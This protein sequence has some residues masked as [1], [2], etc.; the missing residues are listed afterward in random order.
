[1]KKDTEV[2]RKSG[3]GRNPEAGALQ[4]CLQGAGNP[5][6]LRQSELSGQC[7]DEGGLS[8]RTTSFDEKPSTGFEQMSAM[9]WL[10]T[11]KRALP[12]SAER[13]PERI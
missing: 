7:G 1:M 3:P 5:G 8:A 4:E 11:Q 12:Q 6:W 9:I 2:L 10:N 13:R